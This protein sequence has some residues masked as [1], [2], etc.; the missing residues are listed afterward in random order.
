MDLSQP[1]LSCF[2]PIEAEVELPSFLVQS[3]P[4]IQPVFSFAWRLK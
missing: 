2:L 4:R 3:L 1:F